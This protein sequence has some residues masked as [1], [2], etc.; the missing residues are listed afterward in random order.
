MPRSLLVVKKISRLTGRV[1]KTLIVPD[2][3]EN[4]YKLRHQNMNS[5]RIDIIVKRVRLK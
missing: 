1:L 4:I 2:T 3:E 5:H